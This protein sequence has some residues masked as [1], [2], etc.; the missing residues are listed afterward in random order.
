[1]GGQGRHGEVCTNGRFVV[2]AVRRA[3]GPVWRVGG[4]GA[5]TQDESPAPGRF[6]VVRVRGLSCLCLDVPQG[7]NI[8]SARRRVVLLGAGEWRWAK[9]RSLS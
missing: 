2:L 4:P 9:R 3:H 1:M 8:G 5:V 7:H 6:I